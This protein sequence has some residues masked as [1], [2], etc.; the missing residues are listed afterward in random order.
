MRVGLIGLGVMG[1]RIGTNLVKEGKLHVVYNRTTKKADEFGKQY[2]VK[3][4]KS[5]RDLTSDSDVILLMLSDDQAVN[6]V[7]NEIKSNMNGKILIDMS[8]ISPSLSISLASD[9]MKVGGK[10]YDAPVV[11]TSI[12]VEQKRLTVLV[13]GPQDGFQSV[14]ELLSSTASSVLYMGKNGMG[15][16]AKLVNNLLI[17]TYVASMAE[18][19]NLGVNSGLSPEQVAEFL[20]KFSS[21]RSPTSELKAGK[22]ASRDY[23]TQF[24]TKHMRKDLEI[25]DREAQKLGVINPMSALALQLYRMAEYLGLSESDYASV[26][27]VYSRKQ[28]R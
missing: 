8:T 17:G 27:E 25:I 1:Y 3:V 12:M 21:A 26:L 11:G 2:G 22:M 19:F 6:E 23:S 18:A 28:K 13:G 14:K 10:M 20:A 24:A 4:A 5:A 15:L 9:V 16:Y 7:V